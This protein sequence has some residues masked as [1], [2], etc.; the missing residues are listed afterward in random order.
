M[1][2]TSLFTPVASFPMIDYGAIYNN[3]KARR[4]EAEMRKLEYLNS[5]QKERGAF[6]PNLQDEMQSMWDN[7]QKDIEGGDMSFEAK[8]RRQQMYNSYKD[9]AAKALEYS[10]KMNEYEA[11]IL[12]NPQA[13]NAP[14]LIITKIQEDRLRPISI[15]DL[16]TELS[17]Y[18]SLSSFR[19]FTLPELS[20]NVSAGTI[21]ENLKSTGGINNFYDQQ[22]GKLKD[23]VLS[24][25]V[26]TW[27]DINALSEQEE[28]Q[29]IAY[30]LRQKGLLSNNPADLTKVR[31]LDEDSRVMYLGEYATTVG[32]QL[33]NMISNDIM[34]ER[35]KS[36]M[37]IREYNRKLSIQNSVK[38]AQPKQ[39]SFGVAQGSVSYVPPVTRDKSGQ[40]LKRAEPSAV[41]AGF[42]VHSTI[43]GT[44]PAYTGQDGV[45]RY[46][47]KVGYDQNGTPYA[48]VRYNQNVLQANGR[49]GTH[50]AR[51]L[52]EW[53]QISSGAA[54]SGL[55]N[56]KQ[57]DLIE[58]TFEEMTRNV[59]PRSTASNLA[60]ALNR[61]IGETTGQPAQPQPAQPTQETMELANI[62]RSRPRM[63]TN[64]IVEIQTRVNAL[65]LE[66]QSLFW[67]LAKAKE[68]AVPQMQFLE[69]SPYGSRP[70][71][72]FFGN[73]Q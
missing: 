5:F 39:S 52:V 57:A 30:V 48:L 3:A 14:D 42:V 72:N 15:A 43:Q 2:D 13:Y 47:E 4:E 29:A 65:P 64:E 6:A 49:K 56:T 25:T 16:D 1:A 70:N 63:S 8:A 10:G 21:F 22:A 69:G 61:A 44:Q 27:F 11:E 67:G 9:V 62:W 20:P 41:D 17:S 68:S 50:V 55:S 59:Q 54:G 73:N 28:D 53:D 37:E 7:I 46:V 40:F 18:P 45:K 31:N 58:N 60:N 51:E 66:Q 38:N 33:K 34:T 71:I 23:D 35:E 12:A 26:S 19:R 24:Q 36:D 32:N